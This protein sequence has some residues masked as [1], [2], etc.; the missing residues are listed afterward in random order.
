LAALVLL[1]VFAPAASASV[2]ATTLPTT[3]ADGA[4]GV[5]VPSRSATS[6]AASAPTASFATSALGSPAAT[7]L[8]SGVVVS[9]D[10]AHDLYT[11]TGGLVIP[12][13]HWNGA[14]GDRSR[15]AACSDCQWRV[16]QL[17]TKADLSAGTCKLLYVGCPV[18]TTPVRIWLAHGDGPWEVVGETCQGPRPPQTLD[19]VGAQVHD[20]AEAAL[21]PLRAAA[22]PADGVLVGLPAVFRTGQPATGII[23]ADLSVIGLDVSLDSRVR[24]HWV[25][26]DGASVWTVKPGG[27]WPD[28]SVSHV[29]RRAATAVASVEAVWRAQYVVEGLGP[30]AVPGPLLS[31]SQQLTVVVRAAHAH[32]VT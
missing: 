7:V 27:A 21:P 12:A 28:T 26:G 11:G 18:G 30:F 22:Q 31:Q 1:T 4:I 14:P 2:T 23:G 9:P 5:S 24:W 6:A 19:Q 3:V 20:L 15:V 16:S 29:Y 10:P 32:L 13:R 17:C 25:Y 8:P